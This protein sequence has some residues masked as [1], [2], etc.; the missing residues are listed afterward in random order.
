MTY[1]VHDNTKCFWL[2]KEILPILRCTRKSKPK[3]AQ[4]WNPPT[5]TPRN[6]SPIITMVSL[7]TTSRTT[8]YPCCQYGPMA[9]STVWTQPAGSLRSSTT[10]TIPP[11]VFPIKRMISRV[12]S[13]ELFVLPQSGE[14][15]LWP[16]LSKPFCD[17]GAPCKS[18]MTCKEL[19]FAQF[20]AWRR[21]GQ[22]PGMYGETD[23]LKF[24]SFEVI[25]T[26]QYPSG[27]LDST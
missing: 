17:P 21:Y 27:I 26:D 18:K 25:G 20:S 6:A 9:V 13:T 19:F 5:S 16:E 8:W 12:L 7:P 14:L 24:V 23:V 3:I 10:S 1:V 22:A 4:A 15:V 2:Y 11:M